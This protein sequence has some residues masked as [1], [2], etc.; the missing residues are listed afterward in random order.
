MDKNQSL[1]VVAD[2]SHN[3]KE[4]DYVLRHEYNA[5]GQ[6]QEKFGKIVSFRGDDVYWQT[7]SSNVKV[8][9][10]KW[11]CS[12]P[13]GFYYKNEYSCYLRPASEDV[14]ALHCLS[15][16]GDGDD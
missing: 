1:L 2:Y 13:G 4:G 7:V 3:F 8:A 15:R 14:I 11:Y 6:M 5:Y 9:R 10:V 12:P 16:L